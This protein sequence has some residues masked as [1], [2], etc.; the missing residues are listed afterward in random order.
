ML[1]PIADTGFNFARGAFVNTAAGDAPRTI[2]A[3]G[4]TDGT[5]AQPTGAFPNLLQ[6]IALFDGRGF[7]PNSAASPEPPLRFN[8]NVQSLMSVFD[9]AT[10]E[11]IADQTFNMNR[12]IN[13][14]LPAGLLDAQIRDNTERMFP[15]APVDIDCSEATG[16]C[17]VVSQGSDFI[18]RMDFD[19]TGQAD[20]QRA[21][22]AGAVRDEP[23]GAHLHHRS[24]ERDQLGP[25]PARHRAQRRR[26]ARLR[27]LPDDP[28]R[29]RRGPGRQHRPAARALLRAADRRRSS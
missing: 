20:D 14:D 3:D 11:E 6:S 24:R 2:F 22:R 1:A 21:D 29:R 10:N 19:G 8:L 16:K 4:G 9:V 26:H 23:G 27:R 12:G 17:W 28:R 18:V 25:Q 13:F 5:V 7:V 15:S